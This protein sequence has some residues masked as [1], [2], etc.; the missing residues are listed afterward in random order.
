[1]NDKNSDCD[2]ACMR[3]ADKLCLISYLEL[4]LEPPTRRIRPI[5]S[6]KETPCALVLP[7][8]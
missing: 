3:Q 6:T 8:S 2:H 5:Y 7:T 1:M 4:E